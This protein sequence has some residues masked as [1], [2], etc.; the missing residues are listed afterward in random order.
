[1]SF[2]DLR[3]FLRFLEAR[4]DLRRIT[5]EVDPNQDVTIIQH[6][7]LQAN[8][9]A[10]LFENV[11]GSPY[12]LVSNLFG[13]RA[14]VD[15]VFGCPPRDYGEELAAAAA[16]L[17]PPSLSALWGTRGVLRRAFRAR[18]AR[19]RTGPVLEQVDEPADLNRLPC[20]TCWPLD[21]GAFFTL[22]LVHTVDPVTGRGNVGIYRLQ[23]FDASSTGMHWQIE[24]GGG[25][26]FH[27][28]CQLDQ[29]LAVSV[30]LG[31]PPSLTLAAVAP[32]PEGVDERLLA[33]AI[34]GRPLEVVTRPSTGHRVPAHSEF[35][36][37][38][39]VRKGDVRREG[40]FG[41]H[42]GHYS[43]SGDFPVFRVDRVLARR[44]AIYPATV[45]GK[46]PQEDFHI[47]VALQEFALP[48]LKLMRPAI[49]DLWAY[50]ETGFHPLAVLSVKERY[51]REALKHALGLLG[52]GQL[53]L[54]KV[55]IVVSPG[56]DVRDFADVSDQLWANLGCRDGLHLLAPT[57]QDTLDF[58]GPAPNTGSRLVL[59]ATR[60]PEGALRTPEVG[61][62]PGVAD[63]SGGVS[64]IRRLGRAVMIL[65]LT[66]GTAPARV[67]AILAAHPT[68][69]DCLFHV[70]VSDDVPLDDTMLALWG[71]FTRFDP[72][73]D[74]HPRRRE[75]DGNRVI[76]HFP[77]TIDA[78]WKEGYRQPVEFDPDRERRVL[79]NWDRYGVPR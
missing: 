21:G 58:T 48:L 1:M 53:S 59:L 31:G 26:H 19:V 75:A 39:S 47:G 65:R 5:A 51:P 14:R 33:A 64:E 67:R 52:E 61:A 76:L 37:E 74:L 54:S 34:A 27:Q 77:I 68:A 9:P 60:R 11:R 71:W 78:T 10:L 66:A 57:A 43:H 41:D 49:C 23:R 25:F 24:K 55:V 56:T 12:R 72:L 18:L 22:P 35:V 63:F 32:L 45:V 62:D 28:A 46:P 69:S 29:P 40:P 38:G 2:V 16:R 4:G 3:A 42:L 50:P 70:L 36:L 8:G 13:T 6:H 30:F 79:N 20:L 73:R 15:A 7:V 44:D 17:M